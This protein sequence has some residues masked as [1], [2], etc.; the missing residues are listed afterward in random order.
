M[1]LAVFIEDVAELVE[2]SDEFYSSFDLRVP[3]IFRSVLPCTLTKRAY[4]L[5]TF[6]ARG[7][8]WFDPNTLWA[9]PA[10]ASS[11]DSYRAG[12]ILFSSGWDAL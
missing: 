10:R 9:V 11:F 1:T 3:G 5:G 7:K 6:P 4:T 8:R 2:A 12:C